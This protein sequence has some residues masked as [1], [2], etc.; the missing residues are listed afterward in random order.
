V[1][2]AVADGL[3]GGTEDSPKN[4]TVAGNRHRGLGRV[5]NEVAGAGIAG[6][7]D[8]SRGPRDGEDES[9]IRAEG[10]ISCL[11]ARLL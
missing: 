7:V 11:F 2:P 5:Q 6:N 1:E 8:R 9:P 4:V 3:Y 10:T